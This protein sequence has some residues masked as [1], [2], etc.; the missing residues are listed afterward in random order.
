MLLRLGRST[1]RK[2]FL[3]KSIMTALNRPSLSPNCSYTRV[4]ILRRALHDVVGLSSV[5]LV[6]PSQDR[7]FLY[8]LVSF[9]SFRPATVVA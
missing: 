5:R 4:S 3:H 7:D 2:M 1:G 8:G 6:I 9:G